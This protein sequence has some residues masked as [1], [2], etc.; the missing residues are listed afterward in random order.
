MQPDGCV[1][2]RRVEEDAEKGAD[3]KATGTNAEGG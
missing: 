3:L 1:L 2:V